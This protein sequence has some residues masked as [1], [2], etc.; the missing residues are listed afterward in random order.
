MKILDLLDE[1]KS[2][3]KVF[4]QLVEIADNAS[5]R[6]IKETTQ[7]FEK[8]DLVETIAWRKNHATIATTTDIMGV[9]RGIVYSQEVQR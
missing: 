2:S 5:C 9:D 3:T 8:H 6:R 4:K 7:V 1:Q